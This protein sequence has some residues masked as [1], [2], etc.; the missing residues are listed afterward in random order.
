M[1]RHGW[2]YANLVEGATSREVVVISED[3][4]NDT[5]RDSVVV[6][7][8]P[9]GPAGDFAP[10]V[11]GGIARC[12]LAA[13]IAHEDLGEE[14]GPV[15]DNQMSAI[16]AGVRAFLDLDTLINPPRLRRP[17][18]VGRADWW[19]ARGAVHYGKRFGE[20]REIYAVLT[21][22]EWNVRADYCSTVFLTSVDKKWRARWQVSVRGGYAIVC[23]LDVFRYS[24][25]DHRAPPKLT[26][27]NAEELR[28]TAERLVACFEL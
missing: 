1:P 3:L 23:D 7:V 8:W 12:D 16:T 11:E 19:P 18:S 9:E 25:L 27:L 10:E 24:A 6:P 22:D 21:P 2:R 15:D 4:W 26:R 5:M 17:P 13:G 28:Q 14:L 20:Q